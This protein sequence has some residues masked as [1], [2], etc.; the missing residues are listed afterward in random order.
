MIN[1]LILA[2]PV[3]IMP[4]AYWIGLE[5]ESMLEWKELITRDG[6]INAT[7]LR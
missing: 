3:L 1:I 7:R 5:I 4:I 2:S 6:E